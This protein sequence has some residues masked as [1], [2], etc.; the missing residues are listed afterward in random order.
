MVTFRTAVRISYTVWCMF[1]SIYRYRASI[2]A[3]SK[4][5]YR[6]DSYAYPSY[7]LRLYYCESWRLV[8]TAMPHFP[9]AVIGWPDGSRANHMS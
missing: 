7:I 2:E 8:S 6:I 3:P 9:G 4:T 1:G 5:T